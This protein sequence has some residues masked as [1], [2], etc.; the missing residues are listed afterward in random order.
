MTMNDQ[1]RP[2]KKPDAIA[3]RDSDA[4]AV[5]T[6]IEKALAD[7]AGVDL[8][9][10]N[11]QPTADGWTLA[12]DALRFL[13]ALIPR[14]KPRH[15][16]EM[17]SGLSSRVLAKACAPLKPRCAISSI[18]HDP[19]FGPIAAREFQEQVGSLGVKAKFQTAPIVARL[20]GGKILPV[21]HLAANRL[22]TKRPADL[23]VIDGPPVN[24]GGRE[25]TLYQ[26]MEL[27]RPGTLVLL[28]DANRNEERATVTHWQDTLGE[29]IEVVRL[30]GFTKGMTA[31][32]VNEVVPAESL[33]QRRIEAT[34]RDLERLIP[35][36]AR[37]IL[38]DHGMESQVAAGRSA[39]PC[40][41]K[42]GQYWGPPEDDSA[43]IA[44]LTRQRAAGAKFIVF[45]WPVYW[46][47]EYYSGLHRHLRAS[48]TCVIDNDRLVVFKLH[49]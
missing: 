10:I 16:I 18:D 23:L 33:W 5:K 12:P 39:L 36:D 7:A 28:D 42:N 38:V 22:S 44:E 37:F 11:P 14:L 43:A 30:P 6:A 32:I 45:T 3:H 8:S 21:Y 27:T 15:I 26:A 46:W 29:A 19:E 41:E 40:V 13:M 49:R 48:T 20:Y 17:G 25:G 24:L 2:L 35:A 9:W 31:V 47:L 34:R 4:A 1:R